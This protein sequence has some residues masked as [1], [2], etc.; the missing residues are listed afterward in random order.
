M[1]HRENHSSGPHR[2]IIC[3]YNQSSGSSVILS[4]LIR[5]NST[6]SVLTATE[7]MNEIE[8]IPN[9]FFNPSNSSKVIEPDFDCATNVNYLLIIGQ[10]CLI[11]ERTGVMPL[12]A[13]N[14]T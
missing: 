3:F 2:K 7:N 8:A 4:V 12:P 13:A 10:C 14:A 6:A 11:N 1:L 5:Q 9:L